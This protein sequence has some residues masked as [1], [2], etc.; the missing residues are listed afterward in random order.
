MTTT[1]LQLDT[2]SSDLW[3]I[4]DQCTTNTCSQLSP[5]THQLASKGLNLTETRV[6]LHFGDSATGTSANGTVAVD[7]VTLAGIAIPNQAFGAV[8]ETTLSI[9]QSG[10]AGVLGLGFPTGSRIQAAL[11]N[12]TTSDAYFRDTSR[13]GPILSRILMSNVLRMPMFT[14]ELQRSMIDADEGSAAHGQLTVGRMPD[15]LQATKSEVLW[16]PVKL[17]KPEEG[18]FNAPSFAKGKV[19]PLR[20]EIEI[21]G[22]FFDGQR[23][24]ESKIS[25]D[26]TLPTPTRNKTFALVDTGNSQLRGPRDVVDNI[27]DR[28]SMTYQPG[29]M[30]SAEFPCLESKKLEFQ[31]GGQASLTS[32]STLRFL[33]LTFLF[34][35][36][37]RGFPSTHETLSVN[38]A[39]E[40]RR[41]VSPMSW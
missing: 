41:H 27:L 16:V 31:I 14:V 35:R 1:A 20:W 29:V 32:C 9:V 28:A 30:N 8:D 34:V 33:E 10:A 40:I 5:V 19:Y 21:E 4:T 3:A 22:V 6:E 17:Y 25:A 38:H 7:T 24:D 26:S 36:Q 39:R 12:A 2:G 11:A 23:V 37:C 15:D 13:S 18:G